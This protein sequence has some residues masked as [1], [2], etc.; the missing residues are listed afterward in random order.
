V[1]E[2]E[3]PETLPVVEAETVAEPPP[4]EETKSLPRKVTPIRPGKV[5]AVIP[6]VHAP[7]DPGPDLEPEPEPAPAKT[8]E[9]WRI[10][11]PFSR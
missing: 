3:S 4:A 9:G 8:D 11:K 10:P 1:K 6:L 2:P 5:E 7:D